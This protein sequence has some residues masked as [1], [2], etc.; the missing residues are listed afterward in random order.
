[1]GS[2]CLVLDKEQRTSIARNLN[3]LMKLKNVTETKIAQDLRIPIMTVRRL[4]SGETTDPR[5]YTLK[6]VADYFNV[7]IDS[8]I[9]IHKITPPE[10]NFPSKPMFVPIFNWENVKN[11][12][13]LDLSQ[14]QEWI[15]ITL[16]GHENLS[17]NAF[18][19]ESRPSMY[20]PFHIGTLF[21]FDPALKPS[22]GDLVLVNL[23]ENNNELTLRQLS[24]DP[25]DWRL[26]SISQS[27]SV[28]NF[29]KEHHKI[30]AVVYLTL[31]Y[32]RK[33]KIL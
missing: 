25:P 12:N 17:N 30:I 5:V 28:L 26:N 2:E 20:P 15:P 4:L 19:L 7:P 8:I 24:I 11:A 13:T 1:M 16:R 29:S 31:F 3:A 27:S 22:D 32:N 14:W 21:I 33:T 18:A 10:M 23:K 9:G 6:T